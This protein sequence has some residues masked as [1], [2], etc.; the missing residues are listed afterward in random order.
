[1]IPRAA[2]DRQRVS[3][4]TERIASIVRQLVAGAI[5]TKLSDPRLE[6]FT[7]V[8]RVEVSDDLSIAHVHVSVMAPTPARRNL[9]V[10][11]LTASSGR[12]RRMLAR[13]LRARTI[14]ELAFHLDESLQRGFQTVQL[15]DEVMQEQRRSSDAKA[16]PASQD[17]SESVDAAQR[18]D[19]DAV[20]SRREV[21]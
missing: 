9:S 20:D 5:Q 18:P 7:S 1:M 12:L 10:A 21:D 11:A 4:R 19:M 2:G 8:T 14:P 13:Q 17:S 16:A 3:R 15:I 6:P